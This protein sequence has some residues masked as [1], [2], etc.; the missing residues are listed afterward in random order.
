MGK[1][2]SPQA[3]LLGGVEPER[4]Q[5]DALPSMAHRHVAI[6]GSSGRGREEEMGKARGEAKRRKA[7]RLSPCPD[8]EGET[9][10]ARGEGKRRQARRLSPCPNLENLPL[11]PPLNWRL[12]AVFTK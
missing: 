11:T 12:R 10:Q 6:R 8:L 5:A 9:G 2:G 4:A 1:G 3:P 7:R